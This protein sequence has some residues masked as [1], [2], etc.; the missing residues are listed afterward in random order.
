MSNSGKRGSGNCSNCC[1]LYYN[2]Y[3]PS[4]CGKCNFFI[5]GSYVAKSKKQKVD[6]PEAVQIS[7]NIFSIR[8]TYRNDR[9]FVSRN[10]EGHWICLYHTCK[11][12]RAMF[13]NSGIVNSFRFV[14]N[15]HKCSYYALLA[16][17]LACANY[18][19]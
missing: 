17:V 12:K 5:G 8:T 19:I 11:E 9:C 2:K 16:A 10:D 4:N 1:N 3:K 14:R 18:F 15:Y 6:I 7:E 13:C